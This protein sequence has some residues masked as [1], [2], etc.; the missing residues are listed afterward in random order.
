MWGAFFISPPV[1]FKITTPSSEGAVKSLIFV[2]TVADDIARSALGFQ[3]N[4]SHVFAD[5]ADGK[6]LDAAKETDDGDQ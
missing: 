4:A 2:C 5:D 3:I 1:I 6:Q